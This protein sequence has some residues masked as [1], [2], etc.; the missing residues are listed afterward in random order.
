MAGT[1]AARGSVF[2]GDSVALRPPRAIPAAT[3]TNCIAAATSNAPRAFRA[4]TTGPAAAAPSEN[5]PTFRLAAV[6]KI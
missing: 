1:F 6:V 2:T 3:A 5:A 4:T